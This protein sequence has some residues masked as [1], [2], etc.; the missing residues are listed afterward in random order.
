VYIPS[1]CRNCNAYWSWFLWL[2]AGITAASTKYNCRI[3]GC[4][5]RV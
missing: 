3:S 4:K 5:S 2:Y 1:I